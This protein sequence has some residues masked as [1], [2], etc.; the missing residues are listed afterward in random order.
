MESAEHQTEPSQAG[1]TPPALLVT[2]EPLPPP[3]RNLETGEGTHEPEVPVYSRTR[4]E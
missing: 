3:T 1:P 2:H 4:V